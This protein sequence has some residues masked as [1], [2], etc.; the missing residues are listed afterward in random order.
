MVKYIHKVQY[1]ETDKMGITHHSNY[2]RWMEESRTYYLETCGCPYD[3]LENEGIVSPVLNIDVTYKNPTTYGDTV[4]IETVISEYTGL[5]LT[6]NYTMKNIK[7]DTVVCIAKSEHCF[8]SKEGRIVRLK[9]TNPNL[10][11]KLLSLVE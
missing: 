10:D 2:V 1:Y 3:A 5:K 8:L 7:N 4:E 11:E 9:R 6:F